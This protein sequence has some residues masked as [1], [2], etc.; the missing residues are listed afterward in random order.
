[1]QDNISV[2]QTDGWFLCF[3][4]DYLPPLNSTVMPPPIHLRHSA[5]WLK[6]H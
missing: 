6:S 2:Q 3:V 5:R 4:Q 1:M